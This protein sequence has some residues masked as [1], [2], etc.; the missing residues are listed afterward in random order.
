MCTR[1]A[2]RLSDCDRAAEA[3]GAAQAAQRA[4]NPKPTMRWQGIS[5]IFGIEMIR[6]VIHGRQIRQT[7]EDVRSGLTRIGGEAADAQ[8]IAH[9]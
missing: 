2:G 5:V 8:R 1:E 3:A 6:F 4:A 7:D 9:R